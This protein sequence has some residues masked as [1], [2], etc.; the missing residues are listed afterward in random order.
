MTLVTTIQIRTKGD[1]VV[2]VWLYANTIT[3]HNA[4]VP[5]RLPKRKIHCRRLHVISENVQTCRRRRM[6]VCTHPCSKLGGDFYF[7]ASQLVCEHIHRPAVKRQRVVQARMHKIERDVVYL[8]TCVPVYLCTC[9]PVYLCTCVPVYLCTCVPVYLCTC[10]PVYLKMAKYYQ[11]RAP[12]PDI[13]RS[14]TDFQ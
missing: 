12:P 1:H 5:K 11:K 14:L 9:V 4:R 7:A 13:D 6:H 2:L 10:V 8:C 3:P